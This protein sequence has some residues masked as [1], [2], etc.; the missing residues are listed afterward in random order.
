MHTKYQLYLSLGLLVLVPFSVFSHEENNA[1]DKQISQISDQ[2]QNNIDNSEEDSNRNE[3]E[4][5]Q[6]EIDQELFELF[7]KFFDEH[8]TM[9]FSKIISNLV[10]ILKM[11]KASL[12]PEQQRKCDEFIRAFEKN[13]YNYNFPIWAKLLTAPELR[14]D[15]MS[16]KTRTYLNSISTHILIQA[17]SRKLKSK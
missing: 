16:E 9:P 1:W 8:D 17:L 13:K 12:E 11:Q 15:L 2:E 5:T 4:R 10:T 7:S 14:R 3:A 6:Q